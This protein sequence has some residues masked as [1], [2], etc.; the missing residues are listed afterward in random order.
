MPTTRDYYEVLGISRGATEKEVKSAFR[1]LA[2]DLH[3]DVNPGDPTTEER[4]KEVAEAYEVL[5]DPDQRSRYDRFGH[6]GVRSASGNGG[7]GGAQGFGSMQDI[8]GAFFGGNADMFGGA[9]SGD[10]ILV[11]VTVSFVES[12]TGVETEVTVDRVEDCASCS[13]TGAAAGS[14]PAT[15]S[16]CEGQGQVRQVMNTALGQMARARPCPQCSGSGLHITDPCTGCRA[17]GRVRRRSTVAVRV[18][19]GISSGQRVRL[20]G[21]GGAGERGAPAGDLYVEVTAAPDKRFIREGLDVITQARIEVTQAMVGTTVTVPTIAGE[22]DVE[23]RAGVQPG[24]QIRLKGLGFPNVQG[25]GQGDQV[26]IVDVHIPRI[27]SDEGREALRPLTDHLHEMGD[28]DDEGFFGRLRH[29][30]R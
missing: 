22:R 2:R 24:E 15:C 21:R 30:F 7:G 18:P 1:R 11:G 4:F 12:A 17:R 9:A 6:Q 29:A 20:P 14:N 5:S 25:R 8:F 10:D 19:A 3:P 23:L 16:T 27:T 26:V 13:G 28:G